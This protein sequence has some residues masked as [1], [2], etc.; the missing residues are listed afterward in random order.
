[1]RAAGIREKRCV[2]CVP[3]GWAL[4]A[5]TDLPEVSDEDL[6]GYLELRAEKEFP[7]SLS[8]LRLA[9]CRYTLPDGARR[10]TIAAVAARRIA[11]VEQMLAGAGAKLVSLSLGLDR[12]TPAETARPALHFLA[13]GTHV[14]LIIAAGG[15]IAALRSLAGS[16]ANGETP[17]D[18]DGFCREVRIT[19]GSLPGTVRQQV[20]E[21]RFDGPAETTKILRNQTT[22]QLERLGLRTAPSSTDTDIG[23]GA[24]EAASQFLQQKPVAFEFVVPTVPRWQVYAQRFDSRS[25]RWI[26]L[27]VVAL[28]FLPILAFFIHSKIQDGL[29]Q[30]WAGMKTKVEELDAIQQNIHL[31]RPWFDHTPKHLVIFESLIGAFSETSNVWAKSVQ[32]NDFQGAQNVQNPDVQKVTCTGFARS[33]LELTDL[34]NKIGKRPEVS[35]VSAQSRGGD[36]KNPLQFNFTYKWDPS[37][38]K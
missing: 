20:C 36:G 21:A 34:L 32:I 3:P 33:N 8:E 23:D 30:E 22:N 35:E 24:V 38:A 6:R 37:H 12:L 25:R 11:A 10:A 17:F 2:V 26:V 13:N 7:I 16:V 31:Y 9:H 1:L 28:I 15:G 27:G 18:A 5:S 19:L 4:S 14:D 29:E